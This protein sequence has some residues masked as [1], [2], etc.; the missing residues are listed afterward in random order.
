[1]GERAIWPRLALY[2]PLLPVEVEVVDEASEAEAEHFLL[3]LQ[4]QEVCKLRLYMLVC[5]VKFCLILEHHI[6][7]YL[8]IF[9]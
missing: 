1:M 9:A 3:Q 5:R 6:H 8:D 7:L 4:H 2:L